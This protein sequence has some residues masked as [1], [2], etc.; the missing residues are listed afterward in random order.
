MADRSTVMAVTTFPVQ[1][2]VEYFESIYAD[3]QGDAARLEWVDDRPKPALV[4]WLNAVAPSLIRSGARVVVVGCGLGEDARELMR[5]GYDVTAF[6]CSP[7]AVTWAKRLDPANARCYVCA[8]LFEP[9]ARWRHRFDLVVEI[10]T[11]QSL[12]PDMHH[13][14]LSAIVDMMSPHGRLLVICR[15]CDEPASPDDGPPWPLTENELL[16]AA[17]LA[18]LQPADPVSIFMDDEDP[19]AQRMRALFKRQ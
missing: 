19:P 1:T 8:D 18:G 2:N 13:G 5:R 16:E 10:N 14:A 9:P 17:A 12:S 4:N 3:A 7:T 15:G 6:D 11:L